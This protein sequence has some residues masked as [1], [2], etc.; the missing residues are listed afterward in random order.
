[1]LGRERIT[2][3]VH[4]DVLFNDQEIFA[5]SHIDANWHMDIR[6]PSNSV[7]D[8]EMRC[9]RDMRVRGKRLWSY[10]QR[11]GD[12]HEFLPLKAAA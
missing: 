6:R 2:N 4:A 11:V 10:H 9:Q 8:D 5:L 3:G 1:M 7:A 12:L